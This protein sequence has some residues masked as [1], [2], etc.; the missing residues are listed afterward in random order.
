MDSLQ[1]VLDRHSRDLLPPF[2]RIFIFIYV[3]LTGSHYLLLP[4]DFASLMTG[5]SA[6]SV[7]AGV[8][9]LAL[10]RKPFIQ[11][12]AE[13][14]LFVLLLVMGLNSMVHLCFS[15]DIK[16]ST[17]VIFVMA[18]AGFAFPGR[19]PF[20]AALIGLLATWIAVVGFGPVWTGDIV[21]F[22]F[23]IVLGAVFSVVLHTV[24]RNQLA[25]LSSLEDTV[26]QLHQSELQIV[27]GESVLQNLMDNLPAG[28]VVRDEATRVQYANAVGASLLGVTMEEILGRTAEED[29]LEFY[30]EDGSPVPHDERPVLRVLG[31]EPIVNKIYG[32]KKADGDF[33]WTLAN[34]FTIEPE[35]TTQKLVISAF[36]DVTE[37]L[38][39]ER[40]LR[41]LDKMSS[42]GVLAGGI[43]HDF[44]NLLTAIYGNVALAEASIDDKERA[45]D[46]LKRT[47]ESIQLATNL[48][49]QLLTFATGSDPV[50]NVVDIEKVVKEATTFA[51][52]GSSIAV[53]FDID[54]DTAAVEVDAGQMQ[55]AISNIILNAKQALSDAGL[56]N[57]S[58]GNFDD[59]DTGNRLVSVT[60]RDSGPGMEA[61]MLPKIFD[62]YFTTK[63]TGIG[64]GLAT[65]HSI[66]V[67]HGGSIS[68]E[69]S[70]GEG[71]SF[72]LLLPRAT[73]VQSIRQ[74]DMAASSGGLCIDVLV[75]D[76]EEVVLQTVS[77]L[78]EHL[79]HRVVGARDGEEAIS[80]YTKRLSN[81]EPFDV[82][83]MDLTIAGGMGGMEAAG[84]ILKIDPQARLVVSSGYSEG[85]EMAKFKE[86]G[87]C[88]RL[89]KPFRTADL[90]KMIAEV[91][92]NH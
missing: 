18:I 3:I 2:L 60:I 59:P 35:G 87:F 92:S 75:M 65:T 58:I 19:R 53:S 20:Y 73:D 45:L 80:V 22:A 4:D 43:A 89:E 81:K 64:L 10:I 23:A 72:T 26:E 78:L 52:S 32:V 50:R 11:D 69:S 74:S 71:T 49:K 41:T 51:L 91:M 86:L 47:N 12:N 56:I 14:V 88:G 29:R 13:K 38:K 37:R 28:I 83:I 61:E 63:P 16:Q 9:L 70:P 76:D 6:A 1:P 40:Q 44:N 62:P 77:T 24:R 68:V 90:Q 34:A 66:I 15:G 36:V 27:A 67:K 55:Q 42:I 57:I 25:Q 54:P 79:G 84:E 85:A 33:T 17:N 30:L 5:I 7:A 39:A 8:L 82:V 48:T 21:H 46:H 31:G